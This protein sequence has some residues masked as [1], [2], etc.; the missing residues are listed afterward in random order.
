MILGRGRM[1]EIQLNV[2]GRVRG[3]VWNRRKRELGGRRRRRR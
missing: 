3:G 2:I 1:I